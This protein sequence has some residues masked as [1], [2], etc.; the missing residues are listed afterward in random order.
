VNCLQEDDMGM[1]WIGT[2]NDGLYEFDPVKKIVTHFNH[3]D[4][5]TSSL[6]NDLVWAI[7]KDGHHRLWIGTDNGLSLFDQK[8]QRFINYTDD[9]SNPQSMKGNL[10]SG[11]VTEGD[12][13]YWISTDAGLNRF[14]FKTGQFTLYASEEGLKTNNITGFI[15][16][17]KGMLWM[18]TNAGVSRFDPASKSFINFG[19][20]DGLPD[21]LNGTMAMNKSG[22]I[23]VG[24]K[25]IL[26]Y[27]APSGFRK[28]ALLPKV[29][30]TD[31]TVNGQRWSPRQ[32]AEKSETIT[33]H[34]PQKNFSASFD[35]PEFFT[36]EAVNYAYR[37]DGVD[38][39]WVNAGHRNFVTYSSLSPG[40][41]MLHVK[42]ANSDGIW[43]SAGTTLVI[44][45][46]PPFWETW[47]FRVAA[48]LFAVLLI[49]FLFT[50]RVRN[51]RKKEALRNRVNK[52]M[53]DMR[54]K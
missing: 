13:I 41:Y 49:Y 46:Y 43:N 52:Q 38:T 26:M 48:I 14:N 39:K 25:D 1:I 11:M 31:I 42:A 35:T 33:L 27:F 53:A 51:I 8:H 40:H 17:S 21:N 7:Y 15:K 36:G 9:E 28:T 19:E 16:D 4:K 50:S 45:V 30:F 29:Y 18:C 6:C 34:Y 2:Y 3:N 22:Q 47:W 20:D 32:S 10:V 44:N 24:G 37:L 23:I 54:L 12:S 5:D